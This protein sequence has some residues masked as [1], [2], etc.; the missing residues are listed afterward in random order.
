MW[1]NLVF[2]PSKS[3]FNHR[4]CA[5]LPHV[6][7]LS[8]CLSVPVPCRPTNVQA[9]LQCNSNSAAVT[10]DQASGALSYLA[11]GVTDDGSHQVDCNNTVT[12][13][14]LSDLQCGQNYSVSVFSLDESCS[15]VE[16]DKA[17]LQTGIVNMENQIKHIL[18]LCCVLL[19]IMM[20]INYCFQSAHI[21]IHLFT[22]IHL[23][24]CSTHKH[25]CMRLYTF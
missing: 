16:S 6:C 1:K 12:H 3:W 20:T 21:L 24:S 4:H 5:V 8:V 15:S 23:L 22:L 7:P 11:L 2:P 17:Y 13:C 18:N 14:D 19:N 9:S 10:W 25:L